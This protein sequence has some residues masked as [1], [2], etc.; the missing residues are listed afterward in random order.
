[1]LLLGI[2]W[3]CFPMH[4]KISRLNIELTS[5]PNKI[6]WLVPIKYT[7]LER[8]SGVGVALGSESQ[9]L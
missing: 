8:I 6:L 4:T 3:H 5:T 9:Y 2:D 1:M 7:E